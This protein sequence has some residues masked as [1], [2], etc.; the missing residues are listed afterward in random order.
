VIS[1]NRL[2]VAAISAGL[3]TSLLGMGAAQADPSGAPTP[4]ALTGVGSD[5]IQDVM[6]QVANDVTI[7]GAKQIGSWNATG[8]AT[9]NTG[10]AGCSAVARPNGSGAGRAALLT[11]LNAG[12]GCIQ[13]ARSSSLTLTASSPSLTY[14]PMAVDAVSYA[15]TASS[16]LPRSLALSDLQSIY[17]C[18]PAFVGTGPN[19]AVTPQLPQAGSGTRSY[20][21][22]QMN[23]TDADVNANVYPCIVNGTKNGQIIEEHTGTTLDDKSIAPFSI[24]QYTDQSNGLI[25][26]KRGSAVLG[27]IGGT[28]PQLI[29]SNFAI[30]RDVYNVIPTSQIGTAPYSTVFVGAGSLICQDTATILHYGFALNPNCG[31]TTNHS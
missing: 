13:F 27:V 28:D 9:F 26:D 10:K 23:I 24:G 25:Q 16:T 29:N 18:D 17:H 5:T 19:Y 21:E 11:S 3:V 15:V 12:D 31:S 22:S 14:V 7:G 8:S 2:A 6:N 1:K 20:W 4:R 30:K